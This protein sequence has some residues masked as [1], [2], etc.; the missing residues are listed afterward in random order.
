M[1]GLVLLVAAATLASPA[2]AADD[3]RASSALV[4]PPYVQDVRGDG[5]T[6]VFDTA[7]DAAAEV[8]AGAARVDRKSVV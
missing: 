6:V 7:A 4:V 1:R 2:R 3:T 5:F 8:R